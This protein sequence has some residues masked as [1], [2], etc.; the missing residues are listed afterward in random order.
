MIFFKHTYD[1]VLNLLAVHKELEVKQLHEYLSENWVSLTMAQ[2][3]NIIA[4]LTSQ[5]VLVK[6]K[7]NISINKLRI[8]QLEYFIQRVA[9]S[10]QQVEDLLHMKQGE[11]IVLSAGSLFELDSIR[12]D[13][14]YKIVSLEN[15]DTLFFYNSHPYYILW[16][17]DTEWSFINPDNQ[18]RDIYYL[19]G[20]TTFLDT[21]G[22]AL[23]R[24]KWVSSIQTVTNPEFLEQWYL[25]NIIGEFYIECVFPSIINSYFEIYFNAV[26]TMEHFDVESYKEIF[27]MKSECKI[28]LM[29]SAKYAEGL[30]KKILKYF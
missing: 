13:S 10:T 18:K 14:F 2:L 16:M 4:M 22:A 26:K 11:R 27:H 23:Y 9:A 19:L 21:Y 1:A 7:K 5:H 29:R 12:A 24:Q 8:Y 3:Y 20:N 30:K 17:P 6:H 15:P 28:T 25:I